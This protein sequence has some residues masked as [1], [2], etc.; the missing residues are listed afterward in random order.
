MSRSR[1]TDRTSERG[2]SILELMI[3]LTLFGLF[4]SALQ[5]PILIGLRSL[6]SADD[7][8][9]LRLQLTRTLDRFTREASM[10]RN[11]DRAQ[12][13]RFQF[14]AD[15]NG[16]GS[17]S[18]S[19]V[20]EERNINYEVSSGRLLRSDADTVAGQETVLISNLSSLDFNYYE[21]GSTSES[22]SC[23]STGSCGSN[24]CRSE[25]RVVVVTATATRGNETIS[26]TSSAFLENM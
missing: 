2:L 20:P 19:T 11:V 13:Q 18:G 5:E 15:W 7:R 22:T 4:F 17:S 3:V 10:A 8:E 12:D 6:D 26:M 21:S 23:D 1:A 14:D 24:C 16:D 25:V 9:D